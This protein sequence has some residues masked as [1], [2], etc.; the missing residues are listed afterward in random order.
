MNKKRAI[1][2]LFEIVKK[3]STTVEEVAELVYT[4]GINVNIVKYNITLI[5]TCAKATNNIP[6]LEWLYNNGCNI[7]HCHFD[8]DD[9]V[10]A[11]AHS[12]AYTTCITSSKYY[13]K[14]PVY[15]WFE[16]KGAIP[17]YDILG[18]EKD[19]E[20]LKIHQLLFNT[21]IRSWV[22]F[23]YS[24]NTLDE[25]GNT[26]LHSL[27]LHIKKP[28]HK[29][30]LG[31]AFEEMLPENFPEQ[32]FDINTQNDNGDTCLHLMARIYNYT[33]IK[34]LLQIGADKTIRNND[35]DLPIDLLVKGEDG[36]IFYG[37]Y[38]KYRVEGKSHRDACHELLTI[39]KL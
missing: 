8:E 38:N 4:H 13:K 16:S 9:D 29:Y 19:S 26:Y 17:C 36:D 22:N 28:C 10:E 2:H 33:F 35:E 20:I 15:K 18:Y 12:G 23:K 30:Y 1:R 37:Y 31:S 21:R 32:K 39:D 25:Y 14:I 24:I 11:E 34:K 7:N 3:K 6:L 5:Y 27:I